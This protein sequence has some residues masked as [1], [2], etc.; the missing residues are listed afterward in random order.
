MRD[1][2]IPASILLGFVIL[3]AAVQTKE[4]DIE[5]C[6]RLYKE[7]APKEVWEGKEVFI[8]RECTGQ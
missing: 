7:L 1:I 8:I 4:T 2:G 6:V 5:S 3:A